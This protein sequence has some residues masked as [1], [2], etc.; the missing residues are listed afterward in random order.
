MLAP[1]P[2]HRNTIIFIETINDRY[3]QNGLSRRAE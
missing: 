3:A 2:A 1:L